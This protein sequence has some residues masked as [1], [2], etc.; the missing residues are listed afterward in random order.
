MIHSTEL[1]IGDWVYIFDPD[2][3][4]EKEA[5]KV[6]EIREDGIRTYMF[7]D[8]YEE[9][10][11][12]PIPLTP[13][14]LEKNGFEKVSSVDY[15]LPYAESLAERGFYL[16]NRVSGLYMITDHQLMPI[17]YVHEL[18]RVLRCCGLWNLANNLKV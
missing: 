4:E 13:E 3:K 12:E 17:I 5:Y 10:W 11:F 6:S 9:G 7:S 2:Y 14:I 16:E 15:K 8:T 1:Q 18:Q